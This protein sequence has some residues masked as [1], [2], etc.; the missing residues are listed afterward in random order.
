MLK[1]KGFTLIEL[2]VAMVILG[3]IVASV[4]TAFNCGK[5]AWQVGNAMMQKNQ[6]ARGVIDIMSRE[7]SAMCMARSNIREIGLVYSNG[8]FRFIASI[9]AGDGGLCKVGY[10]YNENEK[11]IER[12][13]N[14]N[15]DL[16]SL[17]ID[18]M[19]WQ[20]LISNINFLAFKCLDENNDWHNEWDSRKDQPDEWKLPKAVEITICIQDKNQITKESEF[21]TIAS[22]HVTH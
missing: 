6:K 5:N 10:R 4:Y 17:N 12:G 3:I 11:E 19:D 18:S 22:I 7:I 2:L 1:K 8:E 21:R 20:P 14:T 9:D 16:S 13:F 15:P